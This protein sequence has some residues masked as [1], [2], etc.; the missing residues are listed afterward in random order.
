MQKSLSIIFANTKRSENYFD[1][2]KKIRFKIDNIFFYS[3]KKMLNY[4]IK[5]L[6]ILLKK[7]SKFLKQI[8]L[9]LKF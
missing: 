4:L 7:S 1:A 9:I 8:I 5:L 2:I 6:S 3:S